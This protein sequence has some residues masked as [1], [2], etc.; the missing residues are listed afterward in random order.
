[1]TPAGTLL[2]GCDDKKAKLINAAGA[3]E[4]SLDGAEGAVTAVAVAKNGVLAATASADL[5]VRVYTFADG[6]LVTSFKAPAAAR[7]L[8]FSPNNQALAAACDDKTIQVW[9]VVYTAGQ[10]PPENFGKV[11]Q[12]YALAA[13]AVDLAFSP[14]GTLLYS[15]GGDKGVKTWRF[16][17]E[18]PTKNIAHPNLVDSVAFSPDGKTLATGCHDGKMRLLDVAKGTPIREVNAHIGAMNV[19]APIYCVAWSADGKQVLTGSNDHSLKLW[20]ATNGNMVREFK[21]YAEKTFEKGHKDGVFCA[22]FSPDGKTIAS[23]SSD[24]TIKL[25]NV[26]DGAVLRD[27][28]NPNLKPAAAPASAQAHPGWV[29]GVRFTPDGKYLVSAGGAPQNKGFLAVWSVA[30][31]K[32]VSGEELPLGVFFALAMSPNGQQL[33]LGTGGNPRAAG[34]EPVATYLMKVPGV[35]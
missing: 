20:D 31:G 23:G 33:A 13:P 17:S 35:K 10:P 12:G 24:R 18:A 29:Y 34:Q 4:R 9:N 15:A 7:G 30:D 32:L 21:A 26:A 8:T 28:V 16:A 5:N 1:V 14:D 27:L 11:S 6:K 22:A 3:I 2:A 25:W 19:A